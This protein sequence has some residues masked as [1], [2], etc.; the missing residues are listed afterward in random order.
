MPCWLRRRFVVLCGSRTPFHWQKSNF[1]RIWEPEFCAKIYRC[2]WRN[3]NILSGFS[4]VAFTMRSS[5]DQCRIG[6]KR[7]HN[8]LSGWSRCAIISIT[9]RGRTDCNVVLLVWAA[10]VRLFIDK[11]RIIFYPNWE[12]D[13]CAKI[14]RC[15]WRN[16]NILSGFSGGAF[17]MGTFLS[18]YEFGCKRIH[19]VL[20]G[21]SGCTIIL[22]TILDQLI[23]SWTHRKYL[24]RLL[25]HC[26]IN[27][28]LGQIAN[29]IAQQNNS[30][31]DFIFDN[32]F[33]IEVL[34]NTIFTGK[35]WW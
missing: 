32:L 26:Q 23:L 4:G 25:V 2:T 10:L 29:L 33:A 12:T 8:I 18:Q 35:E 3:K 5:L 1:F 7:N 19:N 27:T 16:E 24:P 14:Y 31:L 6:R 21:C 30:F 15:I 28:F 13:F 9:I 22:I 20:S 34:C 17:T 11:K